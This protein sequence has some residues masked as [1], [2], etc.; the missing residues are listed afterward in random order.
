MVPQTAALG[1]HARHEQRKS[2]QDDAEQD[3]SDALAATDDQGEPVL[4]RSI[5]D[6]LALGQKAVRVASHGLSS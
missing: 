3:Q 4:P 5:D 6:V 2:N 1:Q